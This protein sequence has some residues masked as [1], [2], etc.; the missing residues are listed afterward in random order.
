M[1]QV[2]YS[3]LVIGIGYK[4]RHGKDTVAQVMKEALEKDYK[5]EVIPLAKALKE[6]VNTMDQ[7][8]VCL[9]LGILYDTKPDMTDPLCNTK[10]GKQSRLLQYFGELRRKEDPFYWVKKLR[11]NIA[12]SRPEIVIIPDIRYKNEFAFV[13]AC[14][15]YMIRVSRLGFTDLSRDPKHISETELDGVTFDITIDVMDGD[16]NQL[17]SDAITALKL[18]EAHLTPKNDENLEHVAVVS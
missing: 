8:E 15:G 12:K 13:K 14:K 1:E 9:K 2:T 7:F 5:V 4:A 6:E 3:P 16:L 11:D 17:K 10:H 18:I